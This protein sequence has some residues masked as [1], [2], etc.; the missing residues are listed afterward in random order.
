MSGPLVTEEITTASNYWVKRVQK[1]DDTCL[2]SPG[3]KLIKDEHTGVL[4]CEG[5]IKGY[6]PT[7]LPGGPL[8]EKLIVH[9]HNQVMHLG[10]AN[11]MASVRQGWW[12]P[13]LR[14]KVKKVI[15]KCNVCKVFSTK[16]YGVRSPRALPEYRMEG[17]RP[18]EVTE[19]EFAGPL[20]Y[21]VGKKEEGKCYVI[22]FI[23]ASSRAVHLEVA[24]TQTADEFKNK[25][26]A[27][28]SRRT[29]PRIIISDNAKVFKA[30]ADWVKTVRKSEKLQNYL[31]REKIRWGGIYERLIKEIKKTLHNT[32]GR[33]YLSYEAFESVV[34]DVERNLN[35]R[36]LPY[37]EAEGGEEEV[38]TPNTILWGRD[39]YPVDDTAGSDAEKLT[40]MTKRL[41]DAKAHAWKR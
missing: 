35:N 16:R 28:I 27:F 20:T 14:A 12:I 38:L 22:I 18:F 3:W 29:R 6:R 17:S 10:T 32:L 40:R 19:V 39:V 9:I 34:M 23:C 31:A 2:Q 5:R 8:A 24:R 26:N 21:K 7:Y 36:P 41:G 15:K 30:T 33:S 25:L 11:T 13:K 4:K 37:V 1:A